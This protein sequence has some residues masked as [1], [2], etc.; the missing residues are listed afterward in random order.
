VTEDTR[1]AAQFSQRA[2][3][4]SI[5]GGLPDPTVSSPEQ[6]GL[7]SELRDFEHEV[8]QGPPEVPSRLSGFVML[9]TR[10]LA[11]LTGHDRTY[12]RQM[13]SIQRKFDFY[14]SWDGSHERAATS[15]NT[16]LCKL[17]PQ[18]SVALAFSQMRQKTP[19]ELVRVFSPVFVL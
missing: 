10:Y 18:L 15:G 1:A 12:S 14:S 13:E 3:T 9:Q 5:L 4:I 6:P 16:L 7:T 2:C 8:G 17:Q 11:S 19:V